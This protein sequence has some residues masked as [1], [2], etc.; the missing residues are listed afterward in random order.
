MLVESRFDETL[1]SLLGTGGV[2]ATGGVP[3]R[4]FGGHRG[5]NK[6]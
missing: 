4:Q 6:L 1:R 3:L 2:P 5:E